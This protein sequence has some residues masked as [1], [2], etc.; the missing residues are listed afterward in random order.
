MRPRDSDSLAAE[1]RLRAVHASGLVDTPPDETFDRLTRIVSRLLG[2]PVSLVSIV[3]PERQ[4]F[5]S[6]VGLAEP[7]AARRET[8]LSH[9]FCQHVV[10]TSSPLRIDDAVSHPLVRENLA[11]PDL[12]VRAY[13]GVPLLDPDGHVLGS[14]C[15]IDGEPHA[16]TEEDLSVLGDIAAIATDAMILRREAERRRAAEAQKDILIAE[17]HHR[18]KNTLAS[19][20]AIISLTRSRATDP[21]DFFNKVSGRIEALGRSQDAINGALGGRLMLAD[22]LRSNLAP[23]DDGSRVTLAG[24]DVEIDAE[25]VVNLCLIL[26]ELATNAVKYGALSTAGGRLE[27]GWTQ[28]PD[29]ADLLTLDW[30][31]RVDA[32]LPSGEA[33]GGFGRVLIKALAERFF[34]GA[35]EGR[36]D[37]D[38]YR[39]RLDLSLPGL[40]P[41]R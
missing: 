14:L 17:L 27:I 18:I 12:G 8:P 33:A 5:K 30:R 31:E 3:T 26:N 25:S 34:N 39:A 11:I 37:P 13:L 28:A 36:L 9:S 15:A 1:V 29:R 24:P 4:F 41:Q 16:W 6:Q 2:V 10:Q 7:W 23:F 40:R 21:D 22:L 35:I 38:G 19:V 20:R 32:A